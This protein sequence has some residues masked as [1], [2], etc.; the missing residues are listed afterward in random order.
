MPL[1]VFEKLVPVVE[2]KKYNPSFHSLQ[3]KE[4]S[5]QKTAIL[6]LHVYQ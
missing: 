5:H 4:S 6:F 3:Y 2:T 1:K